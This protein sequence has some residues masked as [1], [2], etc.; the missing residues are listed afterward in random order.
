MADLL[1][2]CRHVQR[3]PPDN[4]SAWRDERRYYL[5]M[6]DDIACSDYL[7]APKSGEKRGFIG[8]YGKIITDPTANYYVKEHCLC[9]CEKNA[10]KIL[11]SMV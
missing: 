6:E 1:A 11:G 8:D 7:H 2:A 5:V 3:M 4:S 9:F 10:V